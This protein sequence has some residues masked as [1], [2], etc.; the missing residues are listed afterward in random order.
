[1][2]HEEETALVKKL[3][4]EGLH[5]LREFCEKNGLTYFLAFGTLIGAARHK[6]YIP[7]DDDIDLLIP[8]DSLNKM[9]A[10]SDAL[11]SEDWELCCYE[12]TPGYC[13]PY[14]KLCYRKNKLLPS[15]FETGFLYGPS[16]DLFPLDYFSG[17]EEEAVRNRDEIYHRYIQTVKKVQPY[18]I[19]RSGTVNRIKRVVRH[20]YWHTL[21]P[22]LDYLY[23]E[24][25]D[26]DEKIALASAG[27]PTHAFY[28]V[29]TYQCVWRYDQYEDGSEPAYLEFEGSPFRVPAKWDEVLRVAYGDYMVLPPP[30]K[31]V[32][33]H[34]YTIRT[35]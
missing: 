24:Y 18:A 19:L 5:Y 4:L 13:F 14:P 11:R 35:L 34:S 27:E 9:I 12:K 1:M 32:P 29:D 21:S 2:T 16:L 6:G 7:W 15:R 20:V 23:R 10:M 17:T 33:K 25:R 26:M 22:K 31:Q 3:C 28:V 8:R 30:E